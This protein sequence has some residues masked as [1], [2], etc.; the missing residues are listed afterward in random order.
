MNSFKQIQSENGDEIWVAMLVPIV[1]NLLEGTQNI[2]IK[3]TECAER[4]NEELMD[5]VCWLDDLISIS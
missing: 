3:H 4:P 2:T 1:P 5:N